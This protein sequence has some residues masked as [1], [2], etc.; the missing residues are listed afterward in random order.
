[1]CCIYLYSCLSSRGNKQY[2]PAKNWNRGETSQDKR[3]PVC[4]VLHSHI[5]EHSALKEKPPLF[6]VQSSSKNTNCKIHCVFV[7]K[8]EW[9]SGYILDEFSFKYYAWLSPGKYIHSCL[10]GTWSAQRPIHCCNK[11]VHE[12]CIMLLGNRKYIS[13]LC[14]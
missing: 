9:N 12:T 8:K 7:P 3:C 13:P 2:S 11:R 4:T 10:V 6:L 14:M 5:K 1:M